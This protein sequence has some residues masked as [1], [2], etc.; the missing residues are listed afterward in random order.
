MR[1]NT[2]V[3]GALDTRVEIDAAGNTNIE[4][5]LLVDQ[6]VGIG[7][8]VPTETFHIVGE[9]DQGMVIDDKIIMEQTPDIKFYRSR[10]TNS[11]H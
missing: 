10:G 7:T 3:S 8:T 4:G 11:P 9:S 5:D 2:L 1:I 6:K